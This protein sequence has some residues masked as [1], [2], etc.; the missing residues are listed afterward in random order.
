V[1]AGF[2]SHIIRD[3]ITEIRHQ[4]SYKRRTQ[5]PG[6]LCSIIETNKLPL[7]VHPPHK[8]KERRTSIDQVGAKDVINANPH[9][10]EV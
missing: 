5:R 2:K 8:T 1:E 9:L 10:K 4:K 3:D 6:P 7:V